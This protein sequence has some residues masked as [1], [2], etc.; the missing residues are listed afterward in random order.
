MAANPLQCSACPEDGFWI[1]G[2][3]ESTSPLPG[4][5]RTVGLLKEQASTIFNSTQ[6][7]AQEDKTENPLWD[8]FPMVLTAELVADKPHTMSIQNN[9]LLNF[10]M[11]FLFVFRL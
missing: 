10:Q 4:P 9:I 1:T 7:L 3:T 5:G 11:P 2:S 6:L 8:I